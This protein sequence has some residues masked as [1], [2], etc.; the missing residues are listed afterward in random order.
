MTQAAAANLTKSQIKFHFLPEEE[1]R[2]PVVWLTW[3]R[4]ERRIKHYHNV[5]MLTTNDV[6]L[7][8][9]HYI[10][11]NTITSV[12]INSIY[13]GIMYMAKGLIRGK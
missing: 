5:K 2:R 1:T 7:K 6:Q 12:R 10:Q 13:E 4:A 3:K 11:H 8:P 9:L